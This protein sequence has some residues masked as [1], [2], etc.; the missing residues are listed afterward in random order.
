M[1]IEINTTDLQE[2]DA[3]ALIALIGDLFPGLMDSANPIAITH[4][5]GDVSQRMEFAREETVADAVAAFGEPPELDPAVAFATPPL[6]SAAEVPAGATTPAPAGAA[7]TPPAGVDLDIHGLPWDPRIHAGT[8][9]KNK[10]QSWT[11][12]RNV[13]EDLKASVTAE[14]KALMAIPG[15]QAVAPTAVP[16]PP[17]SAS[18]PPASAA[19]PAPPAS[20]P[21]VAPAPSPVGVPLPPEAIALA[22]AAALADPSF[23]DEPAPPVKFAG[24]MRKITAAETA[25]TITVVEVNDILKALGLAQ[26]RD[27]LVRHDLIPQFETSMA[28]YIASAPASA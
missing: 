10:D 18:A 3:K 2:A 20:G 25:G 13:P 5:V 28:A 22:Q 12:K 15:P 27:L 6:S 26:T 17:T 14:L 9:G 7:A 23:S 16:L 24:I 11:G 1:H 8:K 21:V 4:T 19:T